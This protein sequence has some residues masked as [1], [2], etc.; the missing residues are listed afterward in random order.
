[1]STFIYS[2]PAPDPPPPDPRAQYRILTNGKKYK[3]QREWSHY[4]FWTRWEDVEECTFP[5]VN[6][7][8]LGVYSAKLFETYEAA[9]AWIEKKIEPIKAH[10]QQVW[11]VVEDETQWHCVAKASS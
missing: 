7:H 11:R 10:Q 6:Q 1:M 3:V 2:Q 9:E 8:D 5:P 4:I